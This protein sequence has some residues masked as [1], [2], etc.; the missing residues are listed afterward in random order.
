PSSS[1][2]LRTPFA[3]E[4]EA[5][6]VDTGDLDLGRPPTLPMIAGVGVAAAAVLALGAAAWMLMRSPQEL[7]PLVGTVAPATTTTT[8]T[9]AAQRPQPSVG[10]DVLNPV[11][12][13][14]AGTELPITNTTRIG[15]DA[16]Q[17]SQSPIWHP[18]PQQPV[19][20]GGGIVDPAGLEDPNSNRIRLGS[21]KASHS[22]FGSGAVSERDRSS[23]RRAGKKAKP[24][25]RDPADTSDPPRTEPRDPVQTK[26]RGQ[27]M[28]SEE[29]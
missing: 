20:T 15:Q 5:V 2:R 10:Q 25:R 18:H 29:F 13:P 21:G 4:I 22:P 7:K 1:E 6:R 23:S 3:N 9:H 26:F 24:E 8:D 17:D 14:G 11:L 19:S 12:P 27:G 28:S 16:L